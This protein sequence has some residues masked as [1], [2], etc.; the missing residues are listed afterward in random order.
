[1]EIWHIGSGPSR[2][3][4]DSVTNVVWALAEEQARKGHAVRLVV[5]QPIPASALE[6]AERLGV[7][8]L[9][10]PRSLLRLGRATRRII[11]TERPEIVHMHAVFALY[12]SILSFVLRSE[13]VPY[14]VTAH[15]GVS[16]GIFRRS[17]IRKAVFSALLE[18]SRF[19]HAAGIIALLP[20]EQAEILSFVGHYSGLWCSIP[21]PL[22]TYPHIRSQQGAGKGAT[23]PRIIFL[24]RLDEYHKGLDVWFEIAGKIPAAT[25]VLYGTGE[26][27]R[28]RLPAALLGGNLPPNVSVHP[29]VLGR[30]KL[31]AIAAATMYLQTSRWE[32]FGISVGEAMMAGVPCAISNRMHM[33]R[34]FAEHDLGLVVPFEANEAARLIRDAL[35][36]PALLTRWGANAR[37][38]AESHFACEHVARQ[39]VDFYERVLRVSGMS[40]P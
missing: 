26:A 9:V 28:R 38:Y 11:Q 33:A 2:F 12:L 34:L 16:S 29:P 19:R 24:G 5:R 40:R 8:L 23:A 7:R 36:D 3:S 30:E 39:H 6:E 25:F 4:T 32:A 22:R 15:G 17:R 10:L 35:A 20:E 37:A 13:K 18:R 21:N 31:K 14:V 1:M 27:R